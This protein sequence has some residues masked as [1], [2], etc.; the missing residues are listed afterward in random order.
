MKRPFHEMEGRIMLTLKV[1]DLINRLNE[2]GYDENT[3]LVF[4]CVD[5]DTGSWYQVPFDRICYGEEFTGHPYCKDVINID[6]DIDSA[7]GYA[8][9]KADGIVYNLVDDLRGLLRNYDVLI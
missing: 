2:I 1:I 8:K 6:V 5:G 3:E 7:K 4:G 9:S